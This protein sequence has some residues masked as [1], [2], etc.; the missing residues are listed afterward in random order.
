MPLYT[1]KE[2]QEGQQTIDKLD[3]KVLITGQDQPSSVKK[4]QQEKE[5]YFEDNAISIT[6]DIV[7][8]TASCSYNRRS[9]I[10]LLDDNSSNVKRRLSKYSLSSLWRK[11]THSDAHET[12]TPPTTPVVDEKQSN[13]LTKKRFRSL[14]NL[15]KS[16]KLNP[17]ILTKDWCCTFGGSKK[18]IKAIM[19]KN[20]PKVK[21]VETSSRGIKRSSLLSASDM[22][23]KGNVTD[24]VGS[25]SSTSSVEYGNEPGPDVPVRFVWDHGGENVHVCVMDGQGI[26]TTV[27]LSRNDKNTECVQE[28]RSYPGV[29]ETTVNLKPGRCEFR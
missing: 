23:S 12:P 3:S 4:Q 6:P 9:S 13:G 19:D 22:G 17:K 25:V 10:I 1:Q 15:S 28:G 27:A 21:P 14:Q 5:H 16:S 18:A 29:W 20:R 11:S 8:R 24:Q 7:P 2:G 26:K